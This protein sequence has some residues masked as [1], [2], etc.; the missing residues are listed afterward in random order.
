MARTKAK[1]EQ[2]EDELKGLA[3]Q[4]SAKNESHDFVTGVEERDGAVV[5]GIRGVTFFVQTDNDRVSERWGKFFVAP[6]LAHRVEQKFSGL[7]TKA[8]ALVG[9]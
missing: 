8:K 2:T 5:F 7:W 1:L 6:P 9:L 3:V 4:S